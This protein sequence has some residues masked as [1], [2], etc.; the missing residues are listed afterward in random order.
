LPGATAA[1][2]SDLMPFAGGGFGRTVFLEGEEE[3]SGEGGR[4]VYCG[5]VGPGFFKTL[6]LPLH[7]GRVLDMS[8]GSET[9]KVVVVNE[10][11]AK[12]FWGDEDP[13]GRR[14]HF[15]GKEEWRTVVGVV[16]DSKFFRLNEAP[17][18]VAWY[19]ISQMPSLSAYL[20]VRADGDP[21]PL[22]GA[23]RELLRELEPGLPR[24]FADT[25]PARI[26]HSLFQ[27]R[28]ISRL[29]AVFGALAL[30]LALIGL[31]G[32]VSYSVALRHRE[33]GIRMAVG[34]RRGDVLW[35]VL[36]QGL[37]LVAAG[38]VCGLLAAWAGG[39]LLEGYLFG[40]R[41]TDLV[42]LAGA[43]LLLLAAAVG[44]ILLPARRAATVDPV[45]ALK[46]E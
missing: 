3:G 26:E 32:V 1:A 27:A 13:V 41:P 44:A 14:F 10:T 5:A 12:R 7:Q 43:P 15:Y 35:L 22:V 31:F 38:L 9:P 4:I 17:E 34:A 8:D 42:T 6:G 29:L 24:G 46:Y 20:L 16:G 19:P 2:V 33:I 21:A 45:R 28:L 18:A 39:R 30:I 25:L 36:G 23:V 40:I 11:M 37:A